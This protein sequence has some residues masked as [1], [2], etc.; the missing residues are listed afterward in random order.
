VYERLLYIRSKPSL[1][2]Y[3]QKEFRGGLKRIKK[4]DFISAY[5]ETVAQ[6]KWAE[7]QV[8]GSQ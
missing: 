7:G 5:Q 4:S 8:K 2:C 6:A 3:A 1:Y